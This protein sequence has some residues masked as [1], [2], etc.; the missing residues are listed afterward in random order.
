MVI[1]AQGNR[2]VVVIHEGTGGG[3]VFTLPSLGPHFQ[4]PSLVFPQ[5]GCGVRELLGDVAPAFP[6]PT[7]RPLGARLHRDAAVARMQHTHTH[8]AQ[9]FA[10]FGIMYALLPTG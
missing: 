2:M 10:L 3:E 5:G 4:W 1:F 7:T 8:P 9:A 6:S